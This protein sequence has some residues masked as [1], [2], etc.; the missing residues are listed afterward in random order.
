MGLW[1][2]AGKKGCGDHEGL[3][4]AKPLGYFMPNIR[5]KE[6]GLV[7]FTI[8]V[9]NKCGRAVPFPRKSFALITDEARA[10]IVE[11]LGQNKVQLAKGF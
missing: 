1:P 7:H 5:T 8:A 10:K 9:C 2:F 6:G 3:F 11:D 4:S